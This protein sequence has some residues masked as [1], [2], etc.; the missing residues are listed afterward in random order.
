MA[1]N[2]RVCNLN[3]RWNCWGSERV[4]RDREE[5]KLKGVFKI[6][7]GRHY[8]NQLG[9]ERERVN[10]WK[11]KPYRLKIKVPWQNFMLYCMRSLLIYTHTH[12]H[13]NHKRI[14]KRS[15][16]SH[17]SHEDTPSATIPRSPSPMWSL[18]QQGKHSQ[19]KI[20]TGYRIANVQ[21]CM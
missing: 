19:I 17:L 1:D 20:Q 7:I 18:L 5:A 12:T 11:K 15:V 3:S 14:K 8:F 10:S 21:A 13:V 2:W 16:C 4:E 9:R 6:W